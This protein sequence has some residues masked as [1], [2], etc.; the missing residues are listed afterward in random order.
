MAD[1][2]Y[3]IASDER[4]RLEAKYPILRGNFHITVLE[5]VEKIQK[6]WGKLPTGLLKDT[7]P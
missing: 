5:Q 2:Q 3:F 7:L 4:N 6:S 1:T